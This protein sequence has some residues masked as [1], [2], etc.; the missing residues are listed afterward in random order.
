MGCCTTASP[1]RAFRLDVV[2]STSE[3]TKY[4][5]TADFE[6][7]ISHRLKGALITYSH[8]K[9]NLLLHYNLST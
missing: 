8:K 3:D 5:S 7:W 6:F 2:F 1:D 4:D 9:E